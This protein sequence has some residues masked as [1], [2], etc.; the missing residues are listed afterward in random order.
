MAER[1]EHDLEFCFGDTQVHVTIVE[2]RDRIAADDQRIRVEQ[3]PTDDLVE[4]LI[5]DRSKLLYMRT[6]K[7]TLKEDPVHG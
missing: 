2:G 5:I 1:I 6:T 3:H 7:R 4:E